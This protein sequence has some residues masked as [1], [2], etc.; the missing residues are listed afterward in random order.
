MLIFAEVVYK[1]RFHASMHNGG[2]SS[3]STADILILI[4][5]SMQFSLTLN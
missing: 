3:R 1:E 4:T 5:H 2:I